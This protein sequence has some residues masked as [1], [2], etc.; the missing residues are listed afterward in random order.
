M[1]EICSTTLIEGPRLDPGLLLRPA[2]RRAQRGGGPGCGHHPPHHRGQHPGLPPHAETDPGHPSIHRDPTRDQAD[3]EGVQGRS[4][5][6][7]EEADGAAEIGRGHSRRVSAPPPGPD[8]DL[9]R[10]VPPPS[11]TGAIHRP[12]ERPGAGTGRRCPQDVPRHGSL[13]QPVRGDAREAWRRL[14]L[15]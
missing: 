6:D 10:V 14:F 2:R 3:P 11:D 13:H 15:I 7:A 8:A 5:G 1:G 12:G 4:A 9:V